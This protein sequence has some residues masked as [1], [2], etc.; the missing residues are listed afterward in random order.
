MAQIN[1]ANREVACKVVYYGPAKAGKTANLRVVHARS[2]E[3]I[4]G[5]LTSISTDGDRTLFFDFLP[6]DLG[7]VAGMVAK[8]HLYAVPYIENQNALRLLV[9][10]GVDG[11]V[12]VADSARDRLDANREALDNLLANLTAIGRDVSEIPVVFQWNRS[13]AIDALSPTELATALDV[14]DRQSFAAIACEGTG[15][16]ATLKAVTQRVLEI[17][18]GVIGQGAPAADADEPLEKARPDFAVDPARPAAP[19][20]PVEPIFRPRWH[21]SVPQES[22]NTNPLAELGR[23]ALPAARATE[24]EPAQDENAPAPPAPVDPGE[25][26]ELA[27]ADSGGAA[28]EPPPFVLDRVADLKFRE[29]EADESPA[30]AAPRDRANWAYKPHSTGLATPTEASGAGEATSRLV[31]VGGGGTRGSVRTKRH[32]S[33][34][35]DRASAPKGTVHPDGT[36]VA[37]R[38]RRPRAQWRAQRI[39][40]SQMAAG[41]LFALVWLAAT[42]FLVKEL[43]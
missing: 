31:T 35:W 18:S 21:E 6:L 29:S 19:A 30:R 27:P 12:F 42:G 22:S 39:P 5:K 34:S 23:R 40:A 16:M 28:P 37:E 26:L 11:I 8:I 10:E 13:D 38:R 9:L 32:R 33:V 4:R 1:F 36:P 17:A 24:P 14:A 15:V 43:L 2:P 7:E 3:R 25:P 20:E 41:A